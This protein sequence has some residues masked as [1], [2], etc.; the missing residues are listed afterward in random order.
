MKNQYLA[1][2]TGDN[3][4]ETLT[5]SESPFIETN[6]L[7][8]YKEK[9]KTPEILNSSSSIKLFGESVIVDHFVLLFPET[10][11]LTKYAD[12]LVKYGAQITEGPG[13][14][15][16]DFCDNLD[17]LPEDISMYFLAV[18]MPSSVILVL[19]APHAPND[20][21]DILL[22]K[23]GVNAVHHVALC[24]D[25]IRIA[26]TSWQKK[27]FIPLSMTP[28]DDGCLCQWFLGNSAEQIIELICRRCGGRETFSCQNVAGLRLS[29]GELTKRKH[30]SLK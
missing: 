13:L 23:R 11:T 15:P 27:G 9:C 17:G 29:E 25:D 4:N 2:T 12:A 10:E 7:L 24:V 8:L 18:L 26:A 21:L 28:Q 22:N 19:V 30:L 3:S 14:W 1:S 20:K 6:G 5:T 16:D